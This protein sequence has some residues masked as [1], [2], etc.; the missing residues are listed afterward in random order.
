MISVGEI[1]SVELALTNNGSST[2]PSANCF[3]MFNISVKTIFL[4]FKK[5]F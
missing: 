4:F 5:N 1:G 3:N 2:V